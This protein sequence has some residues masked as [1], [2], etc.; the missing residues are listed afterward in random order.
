M[1]FE[2]LFSILYAIF[3]V[4]NLFLIT[5][6]K[7]IRDRLPP[8]KSFCLCIKNLA[9]SVIQFVILDCRE[10]W[11]IPS[12]HS[13]SDIP[14]GP[15]LAY[16][17]IQVVTL[18][19]NSLTREHLKKKCSNESSSSSEQRRQSRESLIPILLRYLLQGVRRWRILN[20][21][22][23]NIVSLV[24]LKGNPQSIWGDSS[25]CQDLCPGIVGARLDG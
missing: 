15:I 1:N 24:V 13:D 10:R 17:P 21:K 5:D 6:K 12:M 23:C 2:A 16:F 19:Q 3:S 18:L 4:C 14:P 20:W 11:V 7:W 25:R 22:D 8:S 9:L